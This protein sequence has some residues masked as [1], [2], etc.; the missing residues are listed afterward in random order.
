MACNWITNSQGDIVGAKING[1][2]E[3]S[4]LFDDLNEEFGIDKAVELFAVSES[5]SFKDIF[6]GNKSKLDVT[7]FSEVLDKAVN[8]RTYEDFV[9][10]MSDFRDV[11]SAPSKSTTLTE[12]KLDQGGDFSLLEVAQG[13]HNQP[14]D[15]FDPNV[16]AR[17]YMYNNKQGMESFTA[18]NNVI[19]GIKAGKKGINITAYRAVPKN[20]Y[21][22]TLKDYDWVSF[23]ES[24]AISHGESRFGSK[25]YKLIEQEV[26]LQDLWWDGNDIN[27]FGYDTGGTKKY[28]KKELRKIWDNRGTIKIEEPSK[29][30]VIKYVIEE[31]KTEEKLT[32]E[33]LVDL[34][35][36]SNF[37]AQKLQDAFY[38][39]NGFFIV[40]ESKLVKSGLYNEY[41][42]SS[43]ARDTQ[44]QNKIKDSIE[45][46]KNTPQEE[47]N[48]EEVEVDRSVIGEFNS[49]GKLVALNP[50]LA[51]KENEKQADTFIEVDSV[52]RQKNVTET[53]ITLQ[54]T[55]KQT[56]NN[57]VVGL[58]NLSLETLQ[59]NEG[60]TREVLNEIEDDLIEDSIDVIGL[61]DQ[62]IDESLIDYLNT[63]NTFIE[64]PSTENTK[65]F[66]EKS[67]EYFKRD[68]TP[69]KETVVGE[70]GKEYVK[71][72]TELSEEEV[73]NQQGLIKVD[74][75]T[76]LKTAKEDLAT[77]Y[78]NVRTYK[79]KY[80]KDKTLEEYVQ[81]QIANYSFKDAEVAEAVVLYKMYFS[82]LTKADIIGK[83]KATK[84][85]ENVY[86]MT[87]AQIEAK[88]VELG[89]DANVA[90]QVVAYHGSPYS[91]D[92][93]T[94]NAMGTGEGAQA[95]GWGL[96]FT[97]L[98]SIARNYAKVLSNKN[99][100][101][102]DDVV[103]FKSELRGIFN[104]YE[105]TKN[106]SLPFIDSNGVIDQ[107][108][109]DVFI[110]QFQKLEQTFSLD[111]KKLQDKDKNSIGIL[112]RYLSEFNKMYERIEKRV[113]EY[114]NFIKEIKE[115]EEDFDFTILS[116]K[117]LYKVSLHKGKTPS[118]YTW[119][120]WDKHISNSVVLKLAKAFNIPIKVDDSKVKNIRKR[121]EEAIDNGDSDLVDSLDLKLL[122]AE[123]DFS[124]NGI[125]PIISEIF[126]KEGLNLTNANGDFIYKQISR[127]LK[128]DKD[129]S[130]FLLENGID[131]IKYPAESISRG[132][133][134]DT[135]RG[136]NYVVFDENA[137]TIEEQ[138]QFKKID[139]TTNGFVYNGDVYLNTDSVDLIT[140]IHEFNHLYNKW[141]KENREDVYMQGLSL[142]EAE[143][144]SPNSEIK[145][146]IEFVKTNQPNLSGEKLKE[147]ILTELVG[148]R[149]L[150]LINS[151]KKSDLVSWLKSAWE[152][153]QDMLGLS[154]YSSN[155]IAKMNLKEFSTASAVDLLRGNPIVNQTSNF[156]GDYQYLTE[157]FPSDFYSKFLAEKK[158]NSK[159]F[160][161]FYSNFEINEKGI[162]IINTD[163]IS[164]RNIRIYADENLRQYSILSKQ[165]PNISDDLSNDES[166]SERDNVVNNLQSLEKFQGKIHKL[167]NNE[168]IVK[169]NTEQFIKI[170][171]NIYEAI[172]VLGNLTHFAKVENEVTQYHKV[173]I[174][175]PTSSLKLSDYNYLNE[176]I[177]SGKFKTIK[178]LYKPKKQEVVKD[179]NFMLAPN[180]K[181]TNLSEEN[182][183]KVRTPEFKE[184]FGDWQNNPENSSK[185]LDENGEPLVVYH[186]SGKRFEIFNKP[187]SKDKGIYFTDN[188]YFALD[189][190]AVE[191]EIVQREKN[192]IFDEDFE[193]KLEKN[194][195]EQSDL[196]FAKVYST[197]LNLRNPTIKQAINAN[198]IGKNY[199]DG[200]DGF[201]AYTTGDFGYKG[202]QFVAF[203]PNQVMI[204]NID[205][206]LPDELSC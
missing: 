153:I 8:A 45:R 161:D 132:A 18:I 53:E 1:T 95:F 162:N 185:V 52:I 57:K 172:E 86:E 108:T 5:T 121:I 105:F 180:G 115:F 3:R 91:F 135:A 179:K 106:F 133:T 34:Q 72:N 6:G 193:E 183:I 80:P 36:F 13:F 201:I 24:Y 144:N 174:E 2:E 113:Q 164:M 166:I 12:D 139:L 40:S 4:K 181:P 94:T 197:F 178:D 127:K 16:G 69:K 204:L 114:N 102:V 63:L 140:P 75:N 195:V 41:E 33:Q 46:L 47:L 163:P 188:Y 25:G 118:E 93:F 101:F 21:V 147:E 203:E 79:E 73:Y 123:Y 119:L 71:L 186:G 66:A 177:N 19:R 97:D 89:V 10:D 182:W 176:S 92:R 28:S 205:K 167:N 51:E 65:L 88:L 42:A 206:N 148:R 110:E 85:A 49:F 187:N 98:E 67:D 14:D 61:K 117:N 107:I 27:E 11:H 202:G 129:A 158:K 62:P 43:I 120:E 198:V 31:N 157:E 83:L 173:G 26:S 20:L 39:K 189:V 58:L 29:Q 82:N 200:K 84:L 175:Q 194:I 131:G 143:L 103:D 64:E 54:Q 152:S 142:I 76:Y 32:K 150:E 168:V 138:I 155:Q 156:T 112:P 170:G 190:F 60:A 124:K 128:S 149:G 35:D 68:L 48:I 87:N 159:I 111:K 137:I 191:S 136:F 171:D 9:E 56:E 165:M 59:N 134:S 104:N 81:E 130:L 125:E 154:N 7:V 15:Y 74:D 169:N 30:S 146:I 122:E 151:N 196:K 192:N 90:K 23:S 141:L 37:N 100:Y 17:Y 99:S 77:L 109:L 55:A 50:F 184:F 96:Y 160:R 38:D 116:N 44:L 145:D 126:S 22:T 199:E 78:E 70:E